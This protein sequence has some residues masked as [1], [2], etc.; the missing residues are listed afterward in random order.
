MTKALKTRR[1]F[2]ATPFPCGEIV[3]TYLIFS[4]ASPANPSQE[5]I[6]VHGK[7]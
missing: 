4:K 1:S 3:K 2:F 6:I 7:Y 5:A